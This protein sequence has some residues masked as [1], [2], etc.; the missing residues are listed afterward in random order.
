MRRPYHRSR[1]YLD[2]KLDIAA[3][4]VNGLISPST[5]RRSDP[6]VRGEEETR[7]RGERDSLN[8]SFAVAGIVEQIFHESRITSISIPGQDTGS[9]RLSRIAVEAPQTHTNALTGKS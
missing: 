3:A 5:R 9:L 4:D 2:Y 1:A 7:A 8:T 6:E